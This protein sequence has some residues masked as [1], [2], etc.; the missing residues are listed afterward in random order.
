MGSKSTKWLILM[1]RQGFRSGSAAGRKEGW[2]RVR[3]TEGRLLW[4]SKEAGPAV[5]G[6]AR[7]GAFGMTFVQRPRQV[8]RFEVAIFALSRVFIG[9]SVV[10]GSAPSGQ[11]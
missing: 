3:E 7:G 5:L 8:P 11:G 10:A 6:E 2:W 4:G 9:Q 1:G